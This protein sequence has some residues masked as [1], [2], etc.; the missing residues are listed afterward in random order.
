MAE[1]ALDL[2]GGRC[3]YKL[4][5]RFL[6]C[7]VHTA[8]LEPSSVTDAIERALTS[9]A[10]L[11]KR[12]SRCA[13]QP[14]GEGAE[15]SAASAAHSLFAAR[16]INSGDVFTVTLDLRNTGP[17]PLGQCDQQVIFRLYGEAIT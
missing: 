4:Q 15:S 7:V 6:Q 13:V 17:T 14:A 12:A 16:K 5:H 2:G 10:S 3:Q 9:T 1:A 8:V 11:L